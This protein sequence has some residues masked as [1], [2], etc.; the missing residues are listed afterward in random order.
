ML[1]TI[2]KTSVLFWMKDLK[3]VIVTVLLMVV[4]VN[5]MPPKISVQK[6]LA[7]TYKAVGKVILRR[8]KG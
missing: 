8:L 3:S 7:L 1:A 2:R 5:L 4:Q 6:V